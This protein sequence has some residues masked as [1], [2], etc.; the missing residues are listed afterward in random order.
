[1]YRTRLVI[2]GNGGAGKTS[3]ISAL[4]QLQQPL[5]HQIDKVT[6]GVQ[7]GE[8]V[9]KEEGPESQSVIL[10]TYD[11]AGQDIYHSYHPFF[12]SENAVYIVCYN[13][14]YGM[15]GIEN[16]LYSIKVRAP[17]AS[18]L[19]VGTN[20]DLFNKENI[21]SK[22][23]KTFPRIHSFFKVSS[24]TGENIDNLSK[25]LYDLLMQDPQYTS[26]MHSLVPNSY[27]NLIDTV[28]KLSMSQFDIQWKTLY[29][30]S[31]F[32]DA[33]AF[34][35]AVFALDDWGQIMQ[36][37]QRKHQK[38]KN[39]N[40]TLTDMIIL[41]PQWISDCM[42]ALIST[43]SSVDTTGVV[44]DEFLDKIWQ[45]I[46]L[47]RNIDPKKLAFIMKNFEVMYRFGVR[48]TLVP[49]LLPSV[50]P[51]SFDLE[52]EL[53]TIDKYESSSQPM[54]VEMSYH[55][56]YFPADEFFSRFLV[57][58]NKVSVVSC[59][60]RSGACFQKSGNKLITVVDQQKGIFKY[61]ISGIYPQN[62]MNICQE[63]V[64][65][66]V[67]EYYDL[68]VQQFLSCP[69]CVVTKRDSSGQ[70]PLDKCMQDIKNG[71]MRTECYHCGH[72]FYLNQILLSD[73]LTEVIQN[74]IVKFRVDKNEKM[75]V[76]KKE[77]LHRQFLAQAHERFQYE[78]KP[79]QSRR[80]VLLESFIVSEVRHNIIM[81]PVV[82]NE[83]EYYAF[84][85]CEMPGRFH[86]VEEAVYSMNPEKFK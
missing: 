70:F 46:Y 35:Q 83:N 61:T 4:K 27:I 38:P 7:I 2:L 52:K 54:V 37:R 36:F 23:Q 56:D 82:V 33:V 84:C 8:L 53:F 25:T 19:V 77:F 59:A 14:R 68:E 69:S 20:M 78:L 40:K 73:S 29:E 71:N 45:D 5:E 50:P 76:E 66:L 10:T 28:K 75:P 42:T 48:S 31:G 86:F 43:S 41:N 24:V 39:V 85:L 65:Q 32:K 60:W 15:Q 81:L 18:V 44:T 80:S 9:I 21:P 6:E 57:R 51:D 3:L 47:A 79:S 1:L 74:A 72:R 13:L 26:L 64:Q 11:F 55:F 58:M 62:L 63:I 22:L 17:N 34:E 49:C 16:W 12:I 30:L 67:Q